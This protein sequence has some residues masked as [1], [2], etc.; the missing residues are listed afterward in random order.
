MFHTKNGEHD[1]AGY[2][3]NNFLDSFIKQYVCLVVS[4]ML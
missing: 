2:E 3:E 1:V 4:S